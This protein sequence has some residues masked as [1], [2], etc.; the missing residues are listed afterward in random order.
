MTPLKNHWILG[1]GMP[2]TVT[3]SLA[4][5]PMLISASDTSLMKTGTLPSF[6]ELDF[7]EWTGGSDKSWS[8]SFALDTQVSPISVWSPSSSA[9]RK[10]L[11]NSVWGKIWLLC[12]YI[13]VSNQK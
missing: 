6:W 1:L 11:E 10:E 2:V 12:Y 4:T 8:V 9:D 13:I 3:D 7:V 5:S